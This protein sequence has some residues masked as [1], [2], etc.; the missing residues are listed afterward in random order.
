[1]DERFS[2]GSVQYVCGCGGGSLSERMVGFFF[3]C[4][5]D[6]FTFFVV[7]ADSYS[8]GGKEGKCVIEW[9]GW[10]GLGWIG[11]DVPR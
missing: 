10:F 11:S 6:T 4:I 5:M 7:S 1:M 9:L 3:F 2:V 8:E